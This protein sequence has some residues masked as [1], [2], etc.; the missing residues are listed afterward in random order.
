MLE[1]E[2]LRQEAKIGQIDP[3]VRVEG[4]IR[5]LRTEAP[6]DRVIATVTRRL[7]QT[8][9]D[10]H[11]SLSYELVF[12]LREAERNQEA[13]QLLDQILQCYPDDVLPGINKANVF[14]NSLDEPEE[15]LKCIEVALERAYRTK[16]F[17]RQALGNKARI[18]LKLGRGDELSDVLEEIMSLQMVT[19]IPDV[20][21]ERDFVD[22][23]PSGLIRKNVLDRYNEFRPRRPGDSL[24]DEPPKYKP[25]DDNM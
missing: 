24:A 21:R 13:L 6:L 12:L 2:Q 22:R 17:R 1:Y 19:N 23:A 18:L 15:A 14:F 9:G 11:R 8:D 20:A 3:S 7:E 16:Y 4:W 5:R 10:D 25:S